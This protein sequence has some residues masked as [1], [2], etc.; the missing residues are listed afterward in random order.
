MVWEDQVEVV[1]T[2]VS[3]GYIP[4][5]L[6]FS[7]IF[8]FWC[9]RPIVW[10]WWFWSELW[11]FYWWRSDATRRWRRRRRPWWW[12]RC[13]I[14]PWQWWS[15]RRGWRFSWSQLKLQEDTFNICAH[16]FF[17]LYVCVYVCVCVYIKYSEQ[18]Q[19][20]MD[21]FSSFLQLSL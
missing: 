11:I 4:E 8:R 19:N 15:R 16:I 17:F 13:T 20:R 21:L 12:W 9:F 10:F 5:C 18:Q 1:M 14:W 3:K 2:M 6:L 7:F